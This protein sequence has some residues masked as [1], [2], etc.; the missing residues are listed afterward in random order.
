MYTF[1]FCYL[2]C[3][4]PCNSGCTGG[5][6][7]CLSFTANGQCITRTDCTLS[8]SPNYVTTESNSFT[9][10]KYYNVFAIYNNNNNYYYY[11]YYS[12]LFLA[13]N[14]TCSAGYT[15]NSTCTDCD[16]TSICDIDSPCMNGGQCLQ[17]SPPDNYTCNCTGTEYQGDNC[18]G[19]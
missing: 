16:L 8:S 15:A 18:T 5:H 2:G 3:N 19:E 9:C 12:I 1:I 7:C 10:S 4:S 6:D 17:Y 13:C 14:S 11:Y